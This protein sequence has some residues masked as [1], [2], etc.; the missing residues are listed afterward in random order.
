MRVGNFDGICCISLLEV[1]TPKEREG[2]QYLLSSAVSHVR[3]G[4]EAS[5]EH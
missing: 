4:C 1:L 5:F 2:F 3:G